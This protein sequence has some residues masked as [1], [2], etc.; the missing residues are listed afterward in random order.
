[1]DN[2]TYKD[3]FTVGNEIHEGWNYYTFN[4]GN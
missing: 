1:M 3:I 4:T 2:V